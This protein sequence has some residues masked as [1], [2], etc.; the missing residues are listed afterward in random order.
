MNLKLCHGGQQLQITFTKQ[1]LTSPW[2]P[3]LSSYSLGLCLILDLN[4]QDAK[5]RGD[6]S[7]AS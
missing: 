6:Y 2:C 7:E 5:I 4:A 1:V 3:A